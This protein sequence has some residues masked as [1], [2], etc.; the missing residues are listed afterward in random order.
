[1]NAWWAGSFSTLTTW[2]HPL[3]TSSML[4]LPVPEKR[5]SAVAPS[6]SI[7]FARMLNRLSL[8]KSVVGRAL[9]VLGT[10]HLLCLY[11]PLITRK[12]LL[13]VTGVVIN[14]H[15]TIASAVVAFLKEVDYLLLVKTAILTLG[16]KIGYEQCLGLK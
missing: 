7:R 5:S 14:L 8:A 4:M 9:N 11:I 16:S 6:R 10:S 1:M 13:P 2:E 12:V 15:T 3:D